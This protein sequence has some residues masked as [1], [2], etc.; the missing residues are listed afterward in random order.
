MKEYFSAYLVCIAALLHVRNCLEFILRLCKNF[1]D[2]RL[3][4]SVS[5]HYFK[6]PSFFFVVIF[7]ANFD[8]VFKDQSFHSHIVKQSCSSQNQ[9]VFLITKWHFNGKRLK[10]VKAHWRF[11]CLIPIWDIEKENCLHQESLWNWLCWDSSANFLNLFYHQ[12]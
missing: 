1:I 8:V 11:L 5:V 10:R 2:L 9:H 6:T 4:R 7:A 12:L 3:L